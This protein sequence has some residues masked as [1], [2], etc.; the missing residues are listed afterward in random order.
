MKKK[1]LHA[2]IKSPGC[3]AVMCDIPN[4]LKALQEKVGGYIETVRLCEDLVVICDEKGRLKRKPYNCE[5]CGV[6]LVGDIILCGVNG[7]E[8]DDVPCTFAEAWE[9]F[10]ELWEVD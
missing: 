3:P 5:I 2:L 7:D 6:D 8:F 9:M 4:T 10:P 1:W